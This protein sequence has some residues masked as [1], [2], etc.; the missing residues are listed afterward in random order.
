MASR[1]RYYE[2]PILVFPAATLG[3]PGNGRLYHTNTL[4]EHGD[5]DRCAESRRT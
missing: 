4:P 3:H 1:K 5:R 2:D